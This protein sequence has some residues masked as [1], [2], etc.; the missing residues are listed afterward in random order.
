MISA[1]S[2]SI[3]SIVEAT[4]VNAVAK[5][6]LEFHRSARELKTSGNFPTIEGSVVTFDREGSGSNEFIAAARAEGLEMDAISERRRFDLK[7]IPALRKIVEDRRPDLVVTHSV[8][9]HFLL[10]RSRLWRRFP[11]VAFHHERSPLYWISTRQLSVSVSHEPEN[12]FN[13]FTFKRAARRL[14][15]TLQPLCQLLANTYGDRM[16][17][18]P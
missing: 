13:N 1:S 12:S 14:P 15:I 17:H 3:L 9:S 7:V 5:S 2:L 10:L 4:T 6:V 11:W 8:K 18:M 16:T